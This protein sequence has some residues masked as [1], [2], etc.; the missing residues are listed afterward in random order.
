MPGLLD[1]PWEALPFR[2]IGC[3]WVGVEVRRGWE[4]GWE[5]ELWFECKMNKK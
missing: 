4:E 1:F 3:G 5:G 2:R